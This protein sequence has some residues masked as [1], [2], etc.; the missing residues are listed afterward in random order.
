[1]LI[2]LDH[3]LTSPVFDEM[4]CS[5]GF[6]LLHS[7]YAIPLYIILLFF[8]KTR[9]IAIALLFHIFV[10]TIDCL[11][12]FAKCYDCYINSKIYLI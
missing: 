10:D 12:S 2:D 3:L 4:R 11:W 8:S 5:I 9:I 7:F 6:H 1:M